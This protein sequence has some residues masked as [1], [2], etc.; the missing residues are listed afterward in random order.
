ME[1]KGLMIKMYNNAPTTFDDARIV[2]P[3]LIPQLTSDVYLSENKEFDLK[4]WQNYPYE[5]P[6]TI[7]DTTTNSAIPTS[8]EPVWLIKTRLNLH[9][10][11]VLPE[12]WDGY[13]SPSISKQLCQ[14][15]L[16]FLSCLESEN[17]PTPFI[18]PISGGGIQL[19]WHINNRE[20]EIEFIE[21]N[22]IG[23]LKVHE[24]GSLEEGGFQIND[25]DK[26]R[27]IIKWLMTD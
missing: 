6:Q 26:A 23:F 16:M 27:H 25:F 1:K 21:S 3:G 4:T 20:L 11:S 5:N 10:I 9:K 15:A 22:A 8:N 24:D 2:I 13:G 12:D 7:Y 18:G 14:H 19:E 17:I